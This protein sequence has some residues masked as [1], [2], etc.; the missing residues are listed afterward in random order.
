MS[1]TSYYNYAK[2]NTYNSDK[3]YYRARHEIRK[4]F[5]ENMKRY[6]SRRIKAAI[7]E[8][9]IELSRKTVA[10]LMQEQGLKAI[11]PKSFVPKTTDSSHGKRVAENLLLNQEG[12]PTF[13]ATKPDQVWVSDITYMPLKSGKWAYLATYTDL[14]TRKIVGWKV[15][16]NMRESLVREPLEKALLKRGIK[17]GADLI[18][19]S[20]RGSQY[21]SDNV[22]KL[23]NKTFKITQSMSRKA[24]CY[25]N[26]MAESLW[27]TLKREIQIPKSGYENLEELSSVLFEYID[28]YYNPKRLHSSIGYKSPNKFEMLFYQNAS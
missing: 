18:I 5:L 19:H 24:E 2:G 13:R 15:D 9:G 22:I 21:V 14:Y 28:A 1:R 4:E 23:I 8:K 10:K 3:K 12:H 17:V 27:S 16:D 26:A 25:D 11:Q 7:A 6:G 20:D